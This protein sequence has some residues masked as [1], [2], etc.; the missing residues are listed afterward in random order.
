[1]PFCKENRKPTTQSDT[2]R[3]S[4]TLEAVR[5]QSRDCSTGAKGKKEVSLYMPLSCMP[6]LS[7]SLASKKNDRPTVQKYEVPV[8]D[9]LTSKEK[10]CEVLDQSS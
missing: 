3:S 9:Q 1:M 6:L 7:S 5:R 10:N 8:S 4:L 2:S